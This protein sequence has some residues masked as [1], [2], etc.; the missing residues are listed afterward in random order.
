[1]VVYETLVIKYTGLKMTDGIKN[2]TEKCATTLKMGLFRS[3]I[4]CCAYLRW[5]QVQAPQFS[6]HISYFLQNCKIRQI[7]E[8][9]FVQIEKRYHT[10]FNR[11]DAC[12][13]LQ[14]TQV[15]TIMIY[16]EDVRQISHNPLNPNI[17]CSSYNK[18][19]VEF[20]HRFTLY[21]S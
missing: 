17:L 3:E 4:N 19:S 8:K 11:Y 10:N 12:V 21:H 14:N 15:S 16:V 13:L 1:M 9:G 20:Y 2:C 5:S 7:P 18:K 6:V